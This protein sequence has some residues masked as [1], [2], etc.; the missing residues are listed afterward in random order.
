MI[1]A[2]LSPHEKAL[3]SL[4]LLLLLLLVVLLLLLLL[5]LLRL[6]LRLSF[7]L[8]PR[9]D[10][11]RLDWRFWVRVAID[12]LLVWV[13][14]S[15]DGGG[16]PFLLRGACSNRLGASAQKPLAGSG[17]ACSAGSPGIGSAAF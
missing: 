2:A 16:T 7:S 15:T 17:G 8:P 4:L 6:R 14:A 11:V 5:P 1:G 10:D 13:A 3:R 9:L 12:N